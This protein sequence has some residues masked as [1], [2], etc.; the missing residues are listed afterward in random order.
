MELQDLSKD[1][2]WGPRCKCITHFE[3]VTFWG[4][5]NDFFQNEKLPSNPWHYDRRKFVIIHEYCW[6]P[7][8][9]SGKNTK[10]RNSTAFKNQPWKNAKLLPVF[11]WPRLCQR[12]GTYWPKHKKNG[13]GRF[14]SLRNFFNHIAR[15]YWEKER[16]QRVLHGPRITWQAWAVIWSQWI[17]EGENKEAQ[18][19]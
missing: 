3:I 2:F 8:N 18:E 13:K 4:E 10:G 11:S 1:I 5:I 9:L 14:H 16:P 19:D 15:P 12:Y 17:W 7:S 6:M